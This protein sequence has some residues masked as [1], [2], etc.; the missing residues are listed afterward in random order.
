MEFEEIEF[1][2]GAV[3]DY[4]RAADKTMSERGIDTK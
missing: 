4:H 1:W 3:N 2:M